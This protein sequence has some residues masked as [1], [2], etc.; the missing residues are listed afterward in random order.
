METDNDNFIKEIMEYQPVINIG[1]IGH[2]ANGKSTI[3]SAIA[4]EATQRH[5]S[6]KKQNITKKLGYANAKIFKCP[7]CSAPTCYQSTSSKESIHKCN[8]CSKE[9]EL[10]RHVSFVDVPGHNQLMPTML[11]GTS[12]MNYTIL[13]ESVTNETIPELQTKEHFEIALKAGLKTQLVCLNKLD[14]MSKNKKDVLNVIIK[15]QK[16]LAEHQCEKIPIVPVSGTMDC[17]I[18]VL[19]EYIAK[20]PIPEKR[21]TE[22]YKMIIVRTFNI[23]NEKM[24]IKELKGGVIGG[25]ILQGKIM[26]NDDV[27]IFPGFIEKTSDNQ[28]KYTPLKTKILSINTTL[29]YA[30]PGGLIGI[31]LDIDSAFTG[32]DQLI[33][34]V[35]FNSKKQNVT[36]YD[37]L[38]LKCSLLTDKKMDLTINSE[39]HININSNNLIGICN[40]IDSDIINITLEKPTCLSIGDYVTISKMI[41]GKLNIWGRGMLISGNECKCTHEINI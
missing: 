3:T 29:D 35:M 24:Q 11:N 40:S 36:V 33:G 2:T 7:D 26:V 5:S 27:T 32:N 16:Y 12:V 31:Q 28:W 14:L 10:V 20:L 37:T 23:N 15:M 9:C 38:V 4:K 41:N 21:L 18:D 19:C 34:Q 6:E 13:V 30:I 39:L 22:D 1:I 8:L 17:N 25:S